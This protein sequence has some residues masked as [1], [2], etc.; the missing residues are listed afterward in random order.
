[1]IPHHKS[2]TMPQPA[3]S[4][5]WDFVGENCDVV[6]QGGYPGGERLAVFSAPENRHWRDPEIALAD[7]LI[8]DF[9]AGR[10]TPAWHRP[11]FSQASA[12]IAKA[13]GLTEG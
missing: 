12:T 5:W 11:T 2:A 4:F 7:A 13:A 8:S 10:K 1:M 6:V 3:P 9:I